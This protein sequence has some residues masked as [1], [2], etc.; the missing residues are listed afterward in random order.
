MKAEEMNKRTLSVALSLCAF[1]VT[2]A[3]FA[4]SETREIVA[5]AHRGEHL[6]HPENTLPALQAAIELGM[7]Y[8][9]LDVRTT[10]DGKLVLMHDPTVSRT[11]NGKGE[12]AK[13]TLDQIRELDAGVKFG[14]EF[15]GTKVPTFEE[16][17]RMAHG[18]IGIYVHVKI[19]TPQDLVDILTREGMLDRV[20]IFCE[21]QTYHRRIHA[22]QPSLKVMPEAVNRKTIESAIADLHPKV[23]AFEAADFHDDLI[24]IAKQAGAAVYVDRFDSA[25]N[26]G[27][28]Q[29]AINRGA[30]GIQT[31]RPEDLMKFLRSKGYHK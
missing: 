16:V 15:A 6:H 24:A 20:V 4:S 21:D 3:S 1:L 25:D 23:I 8:A 19:V 31:N 30:D 18:R 5:I 22:L 14:P 7:D 26:P 11:T 29:D 28:Y 2:S 27:G 10:A 13:M 12:I 9:E 17:L